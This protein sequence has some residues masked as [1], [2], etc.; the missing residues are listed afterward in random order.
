MERYF[1]R[2]RTAMVGRERIQDLLANI[3][4]RKLS[5]TL[6]ANQYDL[7]KSDYQKKMAEA[8]SEIAAVK[9]EVRSILQTLRDRMSTVT[10]DL[11]Q[12]RARYE[13]GEFS[14]GQYQRTEKKLLVSL[15]EVRREIPRLQALMDVKTSNQLAASGTAGKPV[16]PRWAIISLSVLGAVII[17]AGAGFAAYK[18]ILE[19]GGFKLPWMQAATE[20]ATI[21]PPVTD[22]GT[23]RPP[24]SDNVTVQPGA[25]DNVTPGPGVS[26]DNGTSSR[27]HWNAVV[28][29][30]QK[31]LVTVKYPD[32]VITGVF[33]SGDGKILTTRRVVR[34]KMM[35]NVETSDRVAHRAEIITHQG[36]LTLLKMQTDNV[37]VQAAEID[38]ISPV[39][40]GDMVALVPYGG[41]PGG[42]TIPALGTVEKI[43]GDGTF[44]INVEETLA[45]Y[46]GAA[47]VKENGKLV[48]MVVGP[49]MQAGKKSGVF[50]V[51]L[52]D[53]RASIVR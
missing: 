8:V 17:I 14:L 2:L 29:G 47:V 16:L 5:G 28:A 23:G 53:I 25:S 30:V 50:A 40:E 10:S 21:K 42:K 31:A 3:E 4:Q 39:K 13:A 11:E 41:C 12:V 24:V 37:T 20:N 46:S 7:L 44:D 6:A 52:T 38:D 36:D 9:S 22:N 18:F 15:D 45:C 27:S 1:N 32:I 51:L 48:A 49:A 35:V 33:V 19:P 43:N 26:S 34:Q